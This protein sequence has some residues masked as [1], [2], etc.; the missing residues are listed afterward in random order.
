MKASDLPV[1]KAHCA[2]CPF[3]PDELGQWRDV[4]Q[5]NVVIE[6]TLFKSHQIT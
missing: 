1:M 3:R 5:A 2:T 4:A 6:R